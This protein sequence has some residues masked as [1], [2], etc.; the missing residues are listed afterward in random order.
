LP[1]YC[2]SNALC[3]SKSVVYDTEVAKLILQGV[4]QRDVPFNLAKP[5]F[6]MRTQVDPYQPMIL[7]GIIDAIPFLR[8]KGRERCGLNALT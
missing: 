1:I 7:G 8:A 5:H 6:V 3:V 2:I 4:Q